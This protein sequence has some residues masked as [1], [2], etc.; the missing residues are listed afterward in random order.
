M[1]RIIVLF[2][3]FPQIANT[4]DMSTLDTDETLNFL[5]ERGQNVTM[6]VSLLLFYLFDLVTYYH[7]SQTELRRKW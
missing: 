6:T 7:Q 4:S 5:S 3:V 1:D 2:C